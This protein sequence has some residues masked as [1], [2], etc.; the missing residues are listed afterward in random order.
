MAIHT[1]LLIRHG[2]ASASWGDHADPGLSNSGKAQAENL[3]NELKNDDLNEFKFITSPKL[4]AIE[5]AQPLAIN[6]KKEVTIRNEFSEIPSD[7]IVN[8]DKQNWL[9]DI[10]TMDINHLPK[11]VKN[12][13]SKIM[14]SIHSIEEDVIIFSHF[15]VINSVVASL[16]KESKLLYFYPDYTSCTRLMIK[17]NKIIE[18]SL[19]DTKKTRINL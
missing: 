11:E 13:L 18:I 14:D 4:R 1:I 9:K 8:K 16:L 12:W 5:T 19:G 2:E 10:M 15:M 3:I 6:Y 17:E 7:G